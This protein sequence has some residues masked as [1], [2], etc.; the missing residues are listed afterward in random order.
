MKVNG[1]YKFGKIILLG[2]NGMRWLVFLL[3]KDGFLVFGCG[4]KDFC[5]VNGV[6]IGELFILEC[7]CE[8]NDIIYVFKFCFNFGE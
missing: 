7:I 5:E 8:D 3:L 2:K 6:K 1:I 4:W